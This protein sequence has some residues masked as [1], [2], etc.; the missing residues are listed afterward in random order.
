MDCPFFLSVLILCYKQFFYN[1]IILFS[2]GV[3]TGKEI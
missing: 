3:V 2:L 1:A